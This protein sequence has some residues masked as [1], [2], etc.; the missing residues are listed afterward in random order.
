MAFIFGKNIF[1]FH[2]TGSADRPISLKSP[3]AFGPLGS[4]HRI[5]LLRDLRR[6]ELTLTANDLT[7]WSKARLRARIQY[8]VDILQEH[9]EDA[10]KQSLLTQLHIQ[11]RAR[12]RS[13][14]CTRPSSSFR[15]LRRQES[16]RDRT[17]PDT[18][19]F[20][21]EPLAS[22]QGISDITLRG[23]PEWLKQCLEMRIRG[24][25]GELETLNWPTKTVKRQ[26]KGSRRKIEVEVSTRHGWQPTLD[27]KQFATRHGIELPE[28]TYILFPS[29]QNAGEGVEVISASTDKSVANW[30]ATSG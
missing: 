28:H 13:D 10:N 22:L 3:R 19:V 26:Q 16:L 14:R 24:E 17:V 1:S 30:A 23:A 9:A 2:I 18:L 12:Q 6:I 11:I 25:G 29:S 27:W 20:V 7:S 8:F 4:P 21:L 15:Y 5:H